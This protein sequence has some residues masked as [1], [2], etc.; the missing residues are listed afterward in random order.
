MSSTQ[1][2]YTLGTITD[3]TWTNTNTMQPYI[4][5][6]GTN[7]NTTSASWVV[8]TDKSLTVHGDADFKGDVKIKG[9]S[10]SETLEAIEERLGILF[11]NNELEERWAELRD[12][13][14]QYKKLE[15]EILEKE[16][17]WDLLK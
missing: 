4:I 6:T 9:K 2:T 7:T 13:A 8:D 15:K 11:R 14:N 17:M 5:S 10:L 16:K 3:F 12:L 1:P